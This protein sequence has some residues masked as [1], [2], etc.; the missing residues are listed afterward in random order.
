MSHTTLGENFI[1]FY[2]I[3]IYREPRGIFLGSMGIAAE[4][5]Q[6]WGFITEIPK[7]PF[8]A[9]IKALAGR[10]IAH[11]LFMCLRGY[12]LSP[13]PSPLRGEGRITRWDFLPRLAGQKIPKKV[14]SPLPHHVVG[15]GPG[16]EVIATQAHE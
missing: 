8:L 1:T 9:L 5:P 13:N 14:F 4:G 10:V 16:D 3:Q 11:K 7:E 2:Y 15:K 12:N 6:I